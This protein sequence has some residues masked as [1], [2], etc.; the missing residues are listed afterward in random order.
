MRALAVVVAV[1]LVAPACG[2]PRSR[3]ERACARAW[4][5]ARELRL[6]QGLDLSECVDE[7]SKLDRETA[8]MQ[9]SVAAHV[10]CVDEAPTCQQVL[11]C[12]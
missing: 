5:C 9:R 7:C 10:R 2:R 12:Q 1:L 4:E 11:E 3:C 6:E 8:T